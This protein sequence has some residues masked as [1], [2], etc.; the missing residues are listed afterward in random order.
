M[1]LTIRNKKF[2][3]WQ[4]PKNFDSV[5]FSP[6]NSR[7]R[8]TPIHLYK[9]GFLYSRYSGSIFYA[10]YTYKKMVAHIIDNI[11]EKKLTRQKLEKL[12]LTE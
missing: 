12:L 11:K 2:Q 4:D 8:Q 1:C 9:F 6:L 10:I 7:H 5:H 3:N